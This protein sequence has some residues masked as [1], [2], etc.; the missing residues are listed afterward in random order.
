MQSAQQGHGGAAGECT[1]HH[2]LD[3]ISPMIMR[4]HTSHTAGKP[5]VQA[6]MYGKTMPHARKGNTRATFADGM[7]N[8][9]TD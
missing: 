2:I 6:R 1:R 4:P 8:I 3:C 7:A 5:R 9:G